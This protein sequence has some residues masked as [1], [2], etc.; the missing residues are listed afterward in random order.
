MKIG[1]FISQ[2]LNIYCRAGFHTLITVRVTM[3]FINIK[4]QKTLRALSFWM[5]MTEEMFLLL[6]FEKKT[7]RTPTTQTSILHNPTKTTQKLQLSLF[8]HIVWLHAWVISSAFGTQQMDFWHYIAQHKK[9]RKNKPPYNSAGVKS[10]RSPRWQ[11]WDTSLSP[12]SGT[13][14]PVTATYE[15]RWG[16]SPTDS[17]GSPCSLWFSAIQ[18]HSFLLCGVFEI[19]FTLFPSWK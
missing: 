1:L 15:P 9:E 18:P 6:R 8:F 2:F 16:A 3:T 10:S 5:Q 4:I 11:D 14:L 17:W 12:G 13:V 19:S 7:T